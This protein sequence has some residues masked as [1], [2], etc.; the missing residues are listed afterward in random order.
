ML[1]VCRAQGVLC[2]KCVVL[3]GHRIPRR[4]RSVRIVPRSGIVV[5]HRVPC[6]LRNYFLP[7][8][9]TSLIKHFPRDSAAS[10]TTSCRTWP[11]L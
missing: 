11:R 6:S 9:A 5:P 4:V 8:V 10:E 7:D 1:E 3:D 2:S